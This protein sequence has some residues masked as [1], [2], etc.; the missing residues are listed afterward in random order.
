KLASMMIEG[1]ARVLTGGA[2]F[3]HTD[4]VTPSW[5][6]SMQQTTV[7]G[8]HIFYRYPARVSVN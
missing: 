3:Y 6:A 4:T 5:A 8:D 1:R 2:V 7:I